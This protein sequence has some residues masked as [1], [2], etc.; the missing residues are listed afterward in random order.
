MKKHE[1]DKAWYLPVLGSIRIGN[2]ARTFLRNVGRNV[3]DVERHLPAGTFRNV[4]EETHTHV[5]KQDG[6]DHDISSVS[7][8]KIPSFPRLDS[9]SLRF[10]FGNR[11]KEK[12]G[13][14]GVGE[15][16]QDPS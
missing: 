3:L 14:D 11:T 6:Q 1:R 4:P 13:A 5:E 10:S 7:V 12:P 16:F 15:G 2:R 8:K 9:L